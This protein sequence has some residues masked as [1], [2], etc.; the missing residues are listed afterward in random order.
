MKYR[1]SWKVPYLTQDKV[2]TQD[3]ESEA[4]ALVHFKAVT[5]FEGITHV[6]VDEIKPPMPTEGVP[7]VRVRAVSRVTLMD[8]EGY[9]DGR[10]VRDDY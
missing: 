10:K 7:T 3:F 2:H 1:V 5:G 4:K 6:R 9:R 8:D